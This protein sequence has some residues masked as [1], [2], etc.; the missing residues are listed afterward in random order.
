L[1]ALRLFSLFRVN[2][3]FIIQ[4]IAF[5][6]LSAIFRSSLVKNFDGVP[7][8][9]SPNCPQRENDYCTD[10]KVEYVLWKWFGDDFKVK[11]ENN[12]KF[13]YDDTD[14]HPR[15]APKF[16]ALAKMR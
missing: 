12:Q 13:G 3:C 15:L 16:G 9:K 10:P 11:F 4:T 2:K 6:L 1:R 14:Q 5:G 7:Q 8:N